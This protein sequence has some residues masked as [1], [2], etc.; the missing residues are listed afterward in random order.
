[1]A[2]GASLALAGYIDPLVAAVLMPISSL[3]VVLS[4]ALARPF[5]LQEGP[6]RLVAGVAREREVPA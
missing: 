4:S 3:T 5:P 1:N 2:L 6:S